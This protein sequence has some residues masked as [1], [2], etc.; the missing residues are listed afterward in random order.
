GP[1]PGP[2]PG[3]RRWPGGAPGTAGDWDRA[4]HS[5]GPGGTCVRHSIPAHSPAV[6]TVG[7][8]PSAQWSKLDVSLPARLERLEDP[9]VPGLAVAVLQ[10]DDPDPGVVPD[11]RP[12]PPA[13]RVDVHAR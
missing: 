1:G 13:P 8:H 7:P 2:P 6:R 5:S 3:R 11:H 12:A 9:D 10:L 4:W